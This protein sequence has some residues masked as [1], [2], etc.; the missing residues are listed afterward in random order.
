MVYYTVDTV[1]TA[2]TVYT[3]ETALHCLDS[4]TY[5]YIYCKGRLTRL[6]GLLSKKWECMDRVD[7]M[8]AYPLDC[9]DY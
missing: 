9:Y 2:Y 7:G 5:S 1:D 4:S 6:Y 8:D 3:I